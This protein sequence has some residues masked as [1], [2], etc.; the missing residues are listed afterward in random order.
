M[1]VTTTTA[2]EIQNAET[3]SEMH[4]YPSTTPTPQHS[5]FRAESAIVET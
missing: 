3:D 5:P 4:P 2:S 1:A